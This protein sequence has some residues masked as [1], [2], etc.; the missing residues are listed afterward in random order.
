MSNQKKAPK[1]TADCNGYEPP[2]FQCSSLALIT[3]GGSPGRADSGNPDT[4]SPFGFPGESF[5]DGDDADKDW[6]W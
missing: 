2:S 1:A 4:Q 5:E 3:L 6:D